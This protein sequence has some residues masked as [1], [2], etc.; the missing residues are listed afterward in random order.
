MELKWKIFETTYLWVLWD[1]LSLIESI[2]CVQ[3]KYVQ[4]IVV[5][6]SVG[7]AVLQNVHVD[8]GHAEK[9]KMVQAFELDIGSRIRS[10]TF[11]IF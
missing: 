5:P 7:T 3:P 6:Q 10:E 4:H 1:Q 9:I 11:R 2:L 8:L